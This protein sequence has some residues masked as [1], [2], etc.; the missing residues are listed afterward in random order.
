ML[1]AQ[2]YG[3]PTHGIDITHDIDVALWFATHAY[4][5]LADGTA[6]YLPLT[7]SDWP[8]KSPV[9]FAVL[10]V[11][12]SLKS[13]IRDV[14]LFAPLGLSAP[15]PVAQKAAF[16]MGAHGLH[17]NRLAEALVCALRLKPGVWECSSTYKGL[18]PP[19]E[20]DEIYSWI[21][22]IKANY[23]RGEIGRFLD[24]VPRYSYAE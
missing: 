3:V 5:N 15:R 10:P 21:L 1:L 17:R 9:I 8:E 6:T 4:T 24:L 18:F 20:D 2:H 12:H 14:D 19:P 11:T 16:F 22:D 7:E 13:S 23:G